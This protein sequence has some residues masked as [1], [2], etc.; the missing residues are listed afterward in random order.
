M[1]EELKSHKNYR[2]FEPSKD[3]GYFI[4]FEH[5]NEAAELLFKKKN[6]TVIAEILGEKNFDV[7]SLLGYEDL[8]SFNS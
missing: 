2:A 6:Q 7:P 5:V 4:V 3:Q 1:H 8:V